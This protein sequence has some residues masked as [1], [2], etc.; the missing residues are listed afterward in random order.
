MSLKPLKA[1]MSEFAAGGGTGAAPAGGTTGQ[2]LE[3]NS[4]ADYDYSWATLGAGT[5]TVTTV[6]WTGG[7]VSVANPTTTPAFTIAG[8][9]GGIPYFSGSAT[10]TSSGALAA[11]ALVIGGGAGLAPATTTTGPG[12]LTALGIT[13]G[14]V[15]GVVTVGGALGTPSSGTLSSCTG[16]NSNSLSGT[17][18]NSGVTASSLVSLGTLTSPLIVDNNVAATF[19]GV[20]TFSTNARSATAWPSYFVVTT[21]ADSNMTASVEA[22]GCDFTAASRNFAAGA[23]TTQR[24]HVFRAP[25][26]TFSGASV[27]TTAINVD[28]ADPIAGANATISNS[29]SLRVGK[30]LC[31]STV[32]LSAGITTDSGNS[33]TL[34]T[35][36]FGTAVSFA[37]ATGVGTFTPN[38][39]F[40][41]GISWGGGTNSFA[42]VNRDAVNGLRI[43][44]AA[45]TDTYNDPSTGNSGTVA[46][47]F[48]FGI[49]APTLT[50]TGTSVTD[51]VASTVYIG[52]APTASTNTTIPTANGLLIG[53]GSVAA[54]TTT[55]YGLNI[56]TP[57]GATNNFAVLIGTGGTAIKNIRHGITGAMTAGAVTVTDTGATANTRYFFTP[58]TLGTV[59]IPTDVYASSRSAGASFVLTSATITDTSTYDW[60]AI[61][62]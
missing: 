11:N 23:I 50:A 16:Y 14:S 45:G 35:A 22:I 28:I 41:G 53:A 33:L 27:I 24:E 12:V 15:G 40:I 8:T 6:G 18:L 61:E 59:T 49:N 3:K 32:R 62:P 36:S 26:Y 9:S 43:Q 38:M 42:A 58:H 55:A 5:G 31:T 4:N 37:S 20:N 29:Y 44:S 34:S 13:T 30:M 2:V 39:V 47:R 7:I 1:G 17:V 56:G 21:P 46:N 54:G 57:T 52:G 60:L 51:T 10:W 48:L 25:T 19:K